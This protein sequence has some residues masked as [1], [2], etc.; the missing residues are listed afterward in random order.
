MRYPCS[1]AEY[2]VTHQLI[3]FI[4]NYDVI[5]HDWSKAV[6]LCRSIVEQNIH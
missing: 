2:T 5:L 6:D 3:P 4:Y 1:L